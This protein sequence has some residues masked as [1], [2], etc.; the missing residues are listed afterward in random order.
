MSLLFLTHVVATLFMLGLIWVVQLVIYPLFAEIPSTA[1]SAYEK[2]YQ[3]RITLIVLPVMSIELITG[4]MILLDHTP[5]LGRLLQW[6]NFA[7]ILMIWAS[8]FFLQVPCHTI[9][10]TQFVPELHRKL[11]ISNWIRT[12]L[13]TVRSVGLVSAMCDV[14]AL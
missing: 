9:L 1:F 4:G 11:V 8:T 10:T 13:W 3:H 2:A 7:G 6:Y 5:E 14:P 12:V